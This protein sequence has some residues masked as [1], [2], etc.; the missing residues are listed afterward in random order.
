MTQHYLAIAA[1]EKNL[2]DHFD[3]G[4]EAF[5]RQHGQRPATCRAHPDTIAL[6]LE[7]GADPALELVP[8]ARVAKLLLYFGP[9]LE[10]DTR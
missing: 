5:N 1:T 2:R 10:K 9:Q 4:T 7:R 3:A 8:D 6:L